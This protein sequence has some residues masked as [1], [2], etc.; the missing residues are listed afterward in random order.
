MLYLNPSPRLLSHYT[1]AL[2]TL[3]SGVGQASS[4]RVQ[5]QRPQVSVHRDDRPEP[6][7]KCEGGQA[8]GEGKGGEMYWPTLYPTEELQS[9]PGIISPTRNPPSGPT[10][11]G[12][13]QMAP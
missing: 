12:D 5:D 3:S 4:P 7:A 13:L 11:H 1:K 2:I 9:Q 6:E 8:A 10:T